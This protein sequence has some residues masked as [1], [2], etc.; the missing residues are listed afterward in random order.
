MVA[1][2]MKWLNVSQLTKT[3][4]R[5]ED[6]GMVSEYLVTGDEKALLVDCGWGIGDLAK[7][8]A[9]LTKL[10]LT[11]VNTHGHRDH[12]SG[13]YLFKDTVHIH[14]ND[15][16]LLKAAYEPANRRR[17]LERYPKETWPPGF[18]AEAWTN[19]PMPRY[20]AFKAP[21]SIDLGGRTVDIVE[22]PGHTP[23]SFCLYDHKERLLFAG[24]NIQAGEVLM[25]MPESLP[26]ATYAKS[27][28][29]LA[30]IAEKIDKIYPSHGPAPL[31]P[32]VLKAMQ[33]GVHKVLDGELKGKP[34]T[35]FLG[36]GLA[37]HFEGCGLLYRGDNLR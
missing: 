23:G 25:M 36:S 22:T 18:D 12:T 30:A 4:W 15:V 28:D 9:D 37:L 16:P 31:K 14:E 19:A 11:I 35:T 26:L 34:E 6:A 20:E 33:A 10:P 1:S 8:V 21:F 24:D 29:K 2:Q 3:V 5:I 27:I 32:D 13:D 17:I 7:V